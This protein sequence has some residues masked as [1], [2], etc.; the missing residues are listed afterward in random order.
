MKENK[1]WYS[2]F[3]ISL[4]MKGKNPKP[5]KNKLILEAK[6]TQ[7]QHLIFLSLSYKKNDK[8]FFPKFIIHG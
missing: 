1:L 2:S 7:Q 8:I 5:Q 3:H 4:R 6:S